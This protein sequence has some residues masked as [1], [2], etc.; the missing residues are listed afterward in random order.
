[1]SDRF[2]LN[3][4]RC[5]PVEVRGQPRWP[6]GPPVRPGTG[7]N[8][9]AEGLKQHE[10]KRAWAPS[11]G[12]PTTSAL[13]RSV[14]CPESNGVTKREPLHPFADFQGHRQAVMNLDR[15]DHA[16]ADG[17]QRLDQRD[18]GGLPRVLGAGAFG[19]RGPGLGKPNCTDDPRWR[20]EDR[21][22]IADRQGLDAATYRTPCEGP[23]PRCLRISSDLPQSSFTA[24][25]FPRIR[26]RQSP[27]IW[28]PL[29]LD[30]P[31]I[32]RSRA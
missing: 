21:L 23:M 28:Q 1:M 24:R 8:R 25:S 17:C 30:A 19:A 3:S 13:A 27:G 20:V 29:L 22:A 12:D 16:C 7:M 6:S 10:R 4:S 18:L 11:V 26:M 14:G 31:M 32:A 15:V 5:W 2:R 9:P